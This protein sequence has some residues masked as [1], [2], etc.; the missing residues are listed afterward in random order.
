MFFLYRKNIHY[1]LLGGDM[2]VICNLFFV[3]KRQ[4][5]TNFVLMYVIHY[6][7]VEWCAKQRQNH[8]ER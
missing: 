5:N 8:P 1:V 2:G 6:S 3:G 7:G 4:K